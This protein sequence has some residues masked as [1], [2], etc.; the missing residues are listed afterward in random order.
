[1]EREASYFHSLITGRAYAKEL[2]LYNHFAFLRGRFENIRQRLRHARLEWRRYLLSR[3]LLAQ[4]SM[5]LFMALALLWL[6]RGLLMGAVSLGTMAMIVQA[7]QRGQ[8]QL[9]VLAAS[10]AGAYQS[11]LFMNTFDELLSLPSALHGAEPARPSKE[12]PGKPGHPPAPPLASATGARSPKLTKS[13]TIRFENVSFAYPGTERLVLDGLSFQLSPGETVMLA[14][15]NGSGK[16]TLFKLIM[17]LYDPTAGRI[18]VDGLDLREIDPSQWRRRISTLFQ[19]F[20]RYQL[21]AAENIWI[22][23]PDGSPDDARVLAAAHAAGLE[24]TAA[25]WPQ[26][27]DTQLGRWLRAGHEPSVGQ[28]QRIALARALLRQGDILLLDEPTS[29]LDAATLHDIGLRLRKLADNRLTLLASHRLE[30]AAAAD[31]VVLLHRGS[32][33]ETGTADELLA[34]KELFAQ[35]FQH[36]NHNS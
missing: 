10:L 24:R 3:E 22:G 36:P 35:L 19:D 2:R 14:G 33:A 5:L 9:A 28:W 7:L 11:L 21:T 34:K 12:A 31:R 6:G 1:M 13:P 4:A 25:G 20:G 23:D 29:A 18:I 17:R 15:A 26:G 8:G 30:L 16:T 32:V 27:L